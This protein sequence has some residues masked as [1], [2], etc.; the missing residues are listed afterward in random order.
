[1]SSM[2]KKVIEF[3]TKYFWVILLA[4]GVIAGIKVRLQGIE[5]VADDYLVYLQ[6]WY[7]TLKENCGFKGL[8]MDFYTYYIP[9]MCIL[10]IATYIEGIDLLLFI[11]IISIVS[12]IFCAITG[13]LIC[14]KL[15]KENRQEQR[16]AAVAFVIL[17]LSPMIMLNGAYWGQCD[18]IYVLFA[19]FSIWMLFSEKYHL[20][21]I[22]FGIAFC[23]KLQ[24]V[25]LLPAFLLYYICNKKFSIWKFLYIPAMYLIGGLP[26]IIAG[27]PAMDVYKIYLGQTNLF[28]QLSMNTPNIWRLFPNKEYD[29]FYMWGIA[30]TIAI[31]CILAFI[32]FKNNYQLDKQTFLLICVCSTGICVMFLPGMHERYTVLYSLLAYMYFIIYDRKKLL[33]AALIDLIVC[34]SYFLYLY[35]IDTRSIY[36]LLAVINIS[37]LFYFVYEALRLL[38][39]KKAENSMK[40]HE[41]VSTQNV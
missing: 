34:M 26:A 30:L 19:L 40:N 29:D 1:M 15:L 22:F 35:G 27:R 41:P 38:K 23:F 8:A 16:W 24:A 5:F 14:W 39:Q 10:A 32:V 18:Y 36:P 37:V 21:F 13:A 31:F 3:I 17:M 2:E 12:E 25:F 20:S 28:D 9:Y 33:L 4:V 11:K 6:P 7:E